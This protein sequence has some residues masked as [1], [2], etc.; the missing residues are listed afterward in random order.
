M[1]SVSQHVSRERH[2]QAPTPQ[3]MLS[4]TD[5]QFKQ[6]IARLAYPRALHPTRH[7][8]RPPHPGGVSLCF[9]IAASHQ[10]LPFKD[11]PNEHAQRAIY[12]GA[13]EAGSTTPILRA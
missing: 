2:E 6:E 4:N 1:D 5:A 7:I 13:A 11:W 9:Q 12:N 10:P 8:R 3:R